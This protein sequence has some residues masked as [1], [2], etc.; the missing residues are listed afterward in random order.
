M[1]APSHANISIT[2]GGRDITISHKNFSNIKLKRKAGDVCNNFTLQILDEDTFEIEA[3]ILAGYNE[4]YF[5]YIDGN[6]NVVKQFKGNILRMDN[7]FVD[8]RVML[9][10]EG[11]V[12]LSA[13]DKFRVR[14]INWNTVPKF[15][16]SD[17][18]TDAD[19][20]DI[21]ESDAQDPSK[22]L[23]TGFSMWAKSMWVGIK[24]TA[25]SMLK[26]NLK[27]MFNT[28]MMSYM[29]GGLTN[30]LT[31]GLAGNYKGMQA[32]FNGDCV[33]TIQ[34]AMD[35]NYGTEDKYN[36]NEYFGKDDKGYYFISQKEMEKVKDEWTNKV[37]DVKAAYNIGLKTGFDLDVKKP[38][39]VYAEGEYI[40]PVKPGK[41]VKCIAEGKPFNYLL[42]TK[43][44]NYKG[45]AFYDGYQHEDNGSTVTDEDGNEVSSGT[46]ATTMLDWLFITLW[47]RNRGNVESAGW[48]IGYI[49]EDTLMIEDNLAQI[50]QSYIEYLNTTIAEKS[51]RVYKT[52]D[53]ETSDEGV[54]H[55][56]NTNEFVA[57]YRCYAD[58]DGKI[59]FKRF[60][61]SDGNTTATKEVYTLYGIDKNSKGY[62][63]SGNNG[64]LTNFNASLNILTA[65]I[66][67]GTG[68]FSAGDISTMNIVTGGT[69]SVTISKSTDFDEGET[70]VP[71]WGVI[72][73]VPQFDVA[74]AKSDIASTFEQAKNMTYK[75]TCTIEGNH[76]LSPMD[77]IEIIIIPKSS[78]LRHHSSGK[79]YILSIDE[80]IQDGKRISTFELIKNVNDL[81]S[82]APKETVTSAKLSSI[83]V[84]DNTYYTV[85]ADGHVEYRND[86]LRNPLDGNDYRYIN[87]DTAH[88][89][90]LGPSKNK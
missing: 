67:G 41:I 76:N 10:L 33:N 75:A 40:V 65:M 30:V 1:S 57:N 3:M 79:Y 83:V 82:T 49:D 52:A 21:S 25:A 23:S 44:Q 64:Y 53:I 90:I 31:W 2:I 47:F 51:V 13:Q 34:E 18:F 16:W 20:Y 46:T 27:S 80:T 68:D 87:Q 26:P 4:I 77:F 24:Q 7:T 9:T 84:K 28:M 19:I 5:S 11:F 8:D 70:Y 89:Y 88:A 14:T 86:V 22:S 54:I 60:D 35:W 85:Y 58:D 12:G 42:E 38:K 45:T 61:L 6:G 36:N 81:A 63:Q 56:V 29:P 39:K 78:G 48:N 37:N 69:T 62:S 43:Y 50:K 74:H 55:V 73:F 32:Y 72:S 71:N 66:T 59:Y 15:E 17:I